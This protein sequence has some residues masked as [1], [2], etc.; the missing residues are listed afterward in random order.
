MS[1]HNYTNPAFCQQSEF[2]PSNTNRNTPAQI[3]RSESTR[4]FQRSSSTLTMS[5]PPSKNAKIGNGIQ[6]INSVS[7][8]HQQQQQ[9][10]CVNVTPPRPGPKPS[11]RLNIQN[12]GSRYGSV[13]TI[14]DDTK[15]NAHSGRYALVPVEELPT[16]KNGRYAV[17]PA[18]EAEMIRSGSTRFAKSQDN[19]DRY[20]S[21]PFSTDEPGNLSD[22]FCSLPP[23]SPPANQKSTEGRLTSA[24]STDFS[25]KSFVFYDQKSMQ[26]YA[27]VPTEDN[28]ELV[29]PNH[30][31]IQMHNGRAHRYAVI[32]TDEEET[33]LSGEFE[34]TPVS[35][36]RIVNQNNNYDTIQ[37][38]RSRGLSP[39]RNMTPKNIFINTASPSKPS[40]Q[41]RQQQHLQQ[42]IP[43]Q[44]ITP[45]KNPIATQKLHELL[46]TPQK[47]MKRPQSNATTPKNSPHQFSRVISSTPKQELT[48]QKLQYEMGMANAI[49][50]PATKKT[51]S[52]QNTAVIQPRVATAQSVYSETTINSL[53]KSWN[54]LSFHKAENATATIGA[55][56]LMLILGGIMN[57]GLCLYLTAN[58]GLLRIIRTQLVRGVNIINE[59]TFS[60]HIQIGRMYYL[61]LG[62]VSGFATVSLGFLGFRSRHCDW[63]PN[64]NYITGEYHNYII[65]NSLFIVNF[66]LITFPF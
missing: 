12:A 45:K 24:F 40:F 3:H 36:N 49:R 29:D 57:S 38:Q 33:C 19:L 62:I 1:R 39:K 8:Y 14:A 59:Y 17:V 34:T 60:S 42:P 61:D 43:P 65:L 27:V 44:Q 9:P 21:S 18:Q 26:R 11:S 10:G 25:S 5:T 7:G 20:S 47:P 56:S 58:V 51:A 32:P 53:N 16:N 28:E 6:R 50:M 15:V 66:Q 37:E 41:Q 48:P 2:F 31:I 30:E 23:I 22:Q 4:S 52:S 63:L 54:N 35:P 55:V 13:S 64:R 46:S